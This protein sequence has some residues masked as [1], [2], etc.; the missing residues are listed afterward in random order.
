MKKL[1]LTA[2]VTLAFA[3]S[4]LAQGTITLSDDDT[5]YG[6]A[7]YA[8]G[9]YYS[10]TFGMEVWE[11]SGVTS[12]P[13]GINAPDGVGYYALPAEGFKLEGTYADQ[14]MKDG[15]FSLG[16]LT[17]PDVTPV[18]GKVALALAVWDTSAPSWAA[19]LSRA[20]GS[21]LA[22]VL[23]F[24]T[25]TTTP[26]PINQ[27]PVIGADIGPGWTAAGM[28]LVMAVPEPG[29]ITLAGLGVAALL[30]FRRRRSRSA[31]AIGLSS[32]AM[33]SFLA[34]SGRPLRVRPEG[35]LENSPMLQRW[36][37]VSTVVE[38]RSDA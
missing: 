26:G 7:I 15:T 38:S 12:V 6:V 4:A 28:D 35:T 3:L 1:V 33:L 17:M 31:L 27:P 9:N 25:P 23:G 24:M 22:G 19:M 2:V 13:A 21:T 37:A 18:G 32:S 11:L 36:V 20:T 30:V 29:M 34:K 10:G 5:Q 14:T 16:E 8:P